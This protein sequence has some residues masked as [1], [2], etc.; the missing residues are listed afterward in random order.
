MKD[1]SIST[2]RPRTS[3]A[4]RRVIFQAIASALMFA[5]FVA[6]AA[7]WPAEKVIKIVIPFSA[8]GATDLLGRALAVELG[9]NLKQTVIV[10]N[11]PGAG[12]GIGAQSVANSTA[13]GYTLLLASGSMFTVNQFIY[14]K[15]GYSLASF[16][17]VAKVASGPMVVTVNADLPVKNTRELIAY[18]KAKSATVDF[19]SAGVGSQ[20]HMAGEAFGDAADI[21][22]SHVPYKGEGPAYA[23]LMAGVV[24]MAVANINAISPLL[25]GGR[26][27]ALSVTG[28]ERSPLLPSVPTTA[29]DG[30]PGFEY[31]GWFAL[32]APAGTPKPVVDRLLAGV[33]DA[34]TQPSMK[35]YLADQGMY[36]SVVASTQLK[37]EIGTE[38]AKWKLLVEKKKIDAN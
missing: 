29:E 15:L 2:L 33:N 31:T 16:E 35:R 1:T 30:L 4:S 28:K 18:V 3:S 17:P 20:T 6:G 26:V 32:L 12:G 22:I 9:K 27:K 11:K 37:Q 7:E 34:V 10:D 24:Q 13:D 21:Q 38:S 14:K 5:P 8:G 19:A 36:A 25:K 23:D